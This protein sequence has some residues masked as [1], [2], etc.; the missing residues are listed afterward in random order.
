MNFV[1]RLVTYFDPIAGH[2]RIAHRNAIELSNARKYEAARRDHRTSTWV[3]PGTSAN[4]EIGAAEE[5]VRNRCR[6]LARDNGFAG[7]I[8]T[9]IA[10]H[11]VGTGIVGAITGLSKRARLKASTAWKDWTEN[12]DYDG[13]HDLNGLQWMAYHGVAESGAALIRF[14]RQKF[15]GKTTLAPL[16]IQVMEPDFIDTMKT[17]STNGGGF[18]DRGIEYD[19]KG[20][21]VAY[22]LFSH[23]PGDVA[24]FRLRKWQSERIPADEV[25]YL[26]EKMRPGQDRGIPALAPSVMT[27]RDLDGYFEAELTRKRIESCL[28]GFIY[29]EEGLDLDESDDRELSPGGIPIE[30]FQPGMITRLRP[31]EEINIS[32]PS[33]SQGV[34]EYALIALRETAAAAGVM[35]EH[36]T[37]DFSRVNYSSWRAGHHGFRRRTERRQ[38]HVAVH[39]MC[40]PIGSRFGEAATAAGILPPTPLEFR[41]T[42]PGFI[43]VDPNKD[44]DA[45]LKNLRM[46]KVTLSQLIEANGYDYLEQLIQYASD[47]KMVEQELGK[48]FRFDG[49]PRKAVSKSGKPVAEQDLI[50]E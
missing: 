43:S 13:D 50:Q 27:L 41:W 28:A 31:G 23:H 8:N 14:H 29:S 12:C 46:G 35:Y 47:L 34:S 37:G 24:Q 6:A 17:G 10:D 25:I 4:A 32:Q 19:N 33:H 26:Y 11:V 9:T 42:P 20:R 1:D 48:D 40:R 49:D 36:A 18:I 2:R 16:K 5:I 15:D 21:K 38:W 30:R 45:D 39:K 7:Q 3:T 22:W 44:A